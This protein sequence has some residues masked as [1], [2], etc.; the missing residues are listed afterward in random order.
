[1]AAKNNIKKEIAPRSIF[2]D[3]GGL[4][5]NTTSWEQGDILVFDSI[6][7]KVKAA[8]VEADGLTVLGCALQSI[9]NGVEKGPYTGVTDNAAS[10]KSGAISGPLYG[11][12]VELNVLAGETL[13]PGDLVYIS[14]AK[15]IKASGTKAIGIYIGSKVIT[16]AAAGQVALC[17]IGSRFPADS[18]RV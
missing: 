1:M 6:A 13:N 10:I 14:D 18:L 5:T 9:I 3:V 8:S 15:T 17:L 16:A 4:V 11:N 12:E 7:H 2:S